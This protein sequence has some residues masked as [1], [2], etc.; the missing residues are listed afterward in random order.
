MIPTYFLTEIEQSD[1]VAEN[2]TKAVFPSLTDH[3]KISK[4]TQKLE[5]HW[6]WRELLFLGINSF[7]GTTFFRSWKHGLSD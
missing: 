2:K 5:L 1:I 3:C 4:K 7:K 6:P